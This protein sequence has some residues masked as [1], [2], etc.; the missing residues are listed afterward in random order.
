MIPVNTLLSLI[1]HEKHKL[2]ECQ[3]RDR[4]RFLLKNLKGV[5]FWGHVIS[6][7]YAHLLESHWKTDVCVCYLGLFPKTFPDD[8][9]IIVFALRQYLQCMVQVVNHKGGHFSGSVIIRAKEHKLLLK[10][11]DFCL[12]LHYGVKL[13]LTLGAIIIVIIKNSITVF[14][15]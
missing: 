1:S 6:V 3:V 13:T 15:F 8:F 9:C 4:D 11:L 2:L 10:I 5:V 12:D 7:F 14:T